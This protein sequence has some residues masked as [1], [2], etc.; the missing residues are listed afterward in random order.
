AAAALAAASLA[1]FAARGAQGGVAGTAHDLGGDAGGTCAVCHLP[2]KAAGE[3]LWPTDMS[4]KNRYGVIGALCYYCHGPGDA[5]GSGIIASN[6]ANVW[7]EHSHGRAAGRNPDG[8]AA[9][10]MTL[11]Y[12][13]EAAGGEFECTTCHNVHDDGFRPFLWDSMD[14]LCLRCHPRRNFVGGQ[15]SAEPGEWGTSYFGATNPGSHPLGTDVPGPLR[16][17]APVDASFAALGLLAWDAGAPGTHNLGPH[18]V[19]GA[20]TTGAGGG[21]VGCNTCH[22]VHGRYPEGGTE[23]PPTEDL[24]AVPQGADAAGHANGAGGASSALC[25]SCH[26]GPQP[27]GYAGA[28]WPNPGGMPFTHPV[29]DFDA[30]GER[31]V[32]ALPAG[33]PAGGNSTAVMQ[34]NLVCGSCHLPH[35]LAAF[36][37]QPEAPP[38]GDGLGTPLLRDETTAICADCHTQGF[39]LHH[40]VG[41]G[42]MGGG[43]FRDVF[44]GNQDDDLTCDDC[45]VAGGAH[46]W[47]VPGM[48]GLDPDWRP[49]DPSLSATQPS[50]NGRIAEAKG[51]RFL[52]ERSLE[53]FRCHTDSGSRFTPT[54][55]REGGR[56]ENQQYQ[57]LG[58]GSHFLGKTKLD[59]AQGRVNGNPWNAK[60]D[61]WPVG[62][63]SRFGGTSD[64][65]VLVCE[66]CHS[67]QGTSVAPESSLLMEEYTEGAVV[68]SNPLCEACHGRGSSK[69]GN[70]PM[71]GDPVSF[72]VDSGREQQTLKTTGG[73]FR[74]PEN[75]NGTGA[76]T[77]NAPT[78][79]ATYP[80]ADAMN[81]DSCHQ[82]HDA[83]AATIILEVR[84]ADIKQVGP[85]LTLPLYDQWEVPDAEGTT[86]DYQALCVQCHEK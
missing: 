17:T 18:L 85:L 46:N 5:G 79:P 47:P 55:G 74:I 61:R 29:D 48:P 56:H 70:H 57:A 78:G 45:H 31:G 14:R 73:P 81:C 27:A 28:A 37:A 3:K 62:G 76:N 50:D 67:L 66:S 4:G 54:R 2:H 39:G 6:L 72:A 51:E 20:T 23:T 38:R 36:T 1:L 71:T 86:Y 44:I 34:P 11:P 49:K 22:A 19:G 68:D 25:E 8:E 42:L 33:W 41:A 21:G 80:R 24:L 69:G 40:P 59:F 13:A 52:L 10:D 7:D 75:P 26:R 82:T 30:L 65:P 83:S 32:T 12:V 58:D 63:Q 84:S 43:R 53:C 60:T 16:Q 35:P 64:E 15:E 77:P 9:S